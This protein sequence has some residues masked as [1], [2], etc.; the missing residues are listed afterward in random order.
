MSGTRVR[1]AITGTNDRCAVMGKVPSNEY[2]FSGVLPTNDITDDFDGISGDSVVENLMASTLYSIH[3]ISFRFDNPSKTPSLDYLGSELF[4]SSSIKLNGYV[5][6]SKLRV[7]WDD[8]TGAENYKWLGIEFNWHY[9]ILVVARSDIDLLL[10]FRHDECNVIY[11]SKIEMLGLYVVVDEDQFLAFSRV[12]VDGFQF[13]LAF[14]SLYL[15]CNV[16]NP[17]MPL[18]FW[19]HD[20]DNPC[21]IDVIKLSGLRLFCYGASL[22]NEG[23]VATKISKFC[24]PFL[25][26]SFSKLSCE[27]NEFGGLP[28]SLIDNEYEFHKRFKYLNLDYLRGYLNDSFAEGLVY[29][30]QKSH[31]DFQQKEFFNLDL[32]E[33]LCKKLTVCGFVVPGLPQLPPFL[34]GK[35]SRCNTKWSHK[36][37]H[38]DSLFGLRFNEA[39]WVVAEMVVLDSSLFNNDEI[40]S[41]DDDRDKIWVNFQRSKQFLLYHSVVGESH[42]NHI[43]NDV[44]FTTMSTKVHKV[45]DPNDTMDNVRLELFDD[46]CPIELKFNV[47]VMNFVLMD[48][49]CLIE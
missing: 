26:R 41:L 47:L 43:Y 44:K 48:A 23:F 22:A 25:S 32:H 37:Q 15:L 4:K 7:L 28:Y 9:R 1:Q 42:G 21:F 24:K 11:L 40:V 35:P 45:T 30:V 36:M 19:A 13:V 46:L 31:K 39:M 16:R 49:L 10:D 38:D 17:R 5:K 14:K 18:L 20:L 6:G 29:E 12:G 34:L 27:S 3:Y 33:I 8:S 2:S